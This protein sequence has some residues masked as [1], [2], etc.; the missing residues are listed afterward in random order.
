MAK[1]RIDPPVR[2]DGLY[3]VEFFR[4]LIYYAL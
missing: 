3:C 1:E 4:F 2:I